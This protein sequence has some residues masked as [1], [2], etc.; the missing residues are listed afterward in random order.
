MSVQIGT[1]RPRASNILQMICGVI[2]KIRR[3]LWRFFSGCCKASCTSYDHWSFFHASFI[4]VRI[5]L[6]EVFP[7]WLRGIL[8]VDINTKNRK[9]LL[10][11]PEGQLSIDPASRLA[12]GHCGIWCLGHSKAL[13]ISFSGRHTIRGHPRNPQV[14]RSG[15]FL[16][17]CWHAGWIVNSYNARLFWNDMADNPK[18]LL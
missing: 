4:S 8:C 5:L 15:N 9:S 16:Q 11:C 17:S 2:C 13:V 18:L 6:I 14:G 7:R 12:S 3:T 1:S 10:F